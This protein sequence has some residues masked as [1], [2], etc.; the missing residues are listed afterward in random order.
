MK[1]TKEI[2]RPEL[3]APA[4]NMEKFFTALHF[5]ADAVYLAGKR[6]G[7]RAFAD[8]FTL[9][10][11]KFCCDYAHERGKKVY[12]TVNIFADND[13]LKEL[14]EYISALENCGADALLVS[15]AGVLRVAKKTAPRLPVHLSTQANCTNS[16]AMEFWRDVGITRVVAA[17]ECTFSDLK[18]M[19][20]VDGCELEIFVHGAMCMAYSGRC[21]LSSWLTG[22]G[23]NKGE[24]VQA[25]RWA[26]DI[27]VAQGEYP[28]KTMR[29]EEDGRGVYL[30]NSK[31][32]CL[33]PHLDT[34]L[35]TG[36]VSL[37]IEGRMKSAHYVGTVVNAY[38]R[39]LNAYYDGSFD[40]NLQQSLME[41][42]QKTSHR[43]FTSGFI[44]GK[45]GDETEN[46]VTS[47]AVSDSGFTASVLDW[48]DGIATVQMRNRFLQGDTLE[49]LSAN[50]SFGKT[51]TIT[52]MTD[53]KGEKVSDAK[54]VQQTL[55]IPCPYPLEKFDIL[56]KTQ[57]K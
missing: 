42:L 52:E 22:R 33:L 47:K 9:E 34:V 41:E 54:I 26:W 18:E 40:K 48:A 39:A 27:S 11:I 16:Q 31:D 7:L 55:K 2:R 8:N 10:E 24:C 20:A 32:L 17:R 25:C 44:F 53:E 28:D 3:L 49:I 45:N 4:G 38:T 23:G 57:V 56:R 37:K 29:I 35:K 46:F 15:D 19:S 21:L 50:D 43:D 51:L 1:K 13:D 5:G 12:V 14:A 36:A 30:F 6:F